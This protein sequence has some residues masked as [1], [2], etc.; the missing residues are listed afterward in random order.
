MFVIYRFDQVVSQGAICFHSASLASRLLFWVCWSLI[1][2]PLSF[3]SLPVS[4]DHSFQRDIFI[5][6]LL[7]SFFGGK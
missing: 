2:T 1:L 5:P 6:R 4:N 7:S 3:T